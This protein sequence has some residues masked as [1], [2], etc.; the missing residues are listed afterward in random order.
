MA[1]VLEGR[2]ATDEAAQLLALSYRQVR[3]LREALLQPGN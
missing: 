3:R 2:Y 1:G